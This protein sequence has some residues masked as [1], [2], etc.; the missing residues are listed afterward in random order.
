V[1]TR[2]AAVF[3]ACGLLIAGAW[4]AIAGTRG[5][6]DVLTFRGA[7]GWQ[8]ESSVGAVLHLA[9]VPSLRLESGSWRIGSTSGP[10]SIL[11][12]AIAAPLA[13]W[14]VWRGARARRM[15]AA[16]LGGVSTLLVLS[17]LLS[18]QFAAWLTPGAAIA[19]AEE[20]LASV[21]LAFVAVFLTELFWVL[22]QMVIVGFTIPLA[23]VVFRNV[24]LVLLAANSIR[25]VTAK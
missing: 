18:A 5:L 8:I 19:W 9:R 22:Y 4:W 15:G 7:T 11:L 24:V 6:Y 14:T 23:L 1:R 20:D 21:G 3:V 25:T 17:A 12:F 13:T 2:A 16:W 10:V